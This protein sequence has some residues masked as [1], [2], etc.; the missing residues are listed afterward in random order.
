[1]NQDDPKEPKPSAFFHIK[2]RI[3][4]LYRGH[5]PFLDKIRLLLNT[6]ALTVMYTCIHMS[7]VK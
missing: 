6:D 2:V 7:Y 1:M 3:F 5:Y 4:V